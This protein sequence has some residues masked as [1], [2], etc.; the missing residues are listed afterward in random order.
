[1][2]GATQN[3]LMAASMLH[4]VAWNIIRQLTR[5]TLEPPRVCRLGRSHW[6][7]WFA[8]T[9]WIHL[10]HRCERRWTTACTSYQVQKWSKKNNNTY[11]SYRLQIEASCK[12]TWVLFFTNVA[13]P[14]RF[15]L[16]FTSKEIF[17]S[18]KLELWKLCFTASMYTGKRG[19]GVCPFWLT[20]IC[21]GCFFSWLYTLKQPQINCR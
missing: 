13:F 6:N 15:G 4:K 14:L 12:N 17:S 16:L 7:I 20:C 1:M 10:K 11:M 2:D 3:R 21:A 8:R 19:L 5:D 9:R 18:L